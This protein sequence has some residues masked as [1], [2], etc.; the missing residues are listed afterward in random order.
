M[1]Q[2]KGNILPYRGKWPRIA[3][4]VFVAPGASVIGDV[5]IGA[6]SSIWFNCVLRADDNPIRIGERVNVQDGSVIHVHSSFQGTY[7]GND[8]TIGHMALLHACNI[9]DKA[10][11]GMGSI[12]LD[13]CTIETHGML[14]G[15]AMLTPGKTVPS[16]QMWGGRPAKFMRALSEEEMAG[17]DWSFNSYAERAGE[18]RDEFAALSKDENLSTT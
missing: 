12:V 10:F 15:G 13:Q 17:F 3:D 16:G 2:L 4:N 8:I 6:G 14:A 1:T 7:I 18:Y 9:E 11:V 5:K